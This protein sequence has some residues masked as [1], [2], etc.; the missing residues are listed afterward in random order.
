MIVLT[1]QIFPALVKDLVPCWTRWYPWW[2]LNVQ[3]KVHSSRS[4][5]VCVHSL[6][7]S[8]L[9][10]SRHSSIGAKDFSMRGVGDIIHSISV[11]QLPWSAVFPVTSL[12]TCHLIYWG[13]LHCWPKNQ[14]DQSLHEAID[15]MAQA[16]QAACPDEIQGIV[17]Q[18]Q[19]LESYEPIIR[20]IF[21]IK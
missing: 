9:Y 13:H 4:S 10:H 15:T 12:G 1:L 6:P 3:G 11:L 5:T 7:H 20:G 14:V 2:S 19:S 8:Q 21:L 16:G 17:Q 18:V